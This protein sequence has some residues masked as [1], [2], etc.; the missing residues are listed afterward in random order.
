MRYF[1]LFEVFN[2]LGKRSL[3]DASTQTNI[4]RAFAWSGKCPSGICL[5]GK[6]SVGDVS[7]RGSFRRGCVWSGKCPSG[8]S[9]SGICPSGMC[10]GVVNQFLSSSCWLQKKIETSWRN[11]LLLLKNQAKRN[12][13]NVQTTLDY[14]STTAVMLVIF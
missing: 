7:G 8:K 14:L 13:T 4:C 3:W 6:V 10:P 11:Y 9:P 1:R 5:V 12:T 2:R